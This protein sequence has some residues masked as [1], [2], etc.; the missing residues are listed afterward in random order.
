[1]FVKLPVNA[2]PLQGLGPQLRSQFRYDGFLTRVELEEE[3]SSISQQRAFFSRMSD[4][5]KCSI[6]MTKWKHSAVTL[7]LPSTLRLSG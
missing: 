2:I 1:M 3:G 6:S 7:M 5:P 4:S